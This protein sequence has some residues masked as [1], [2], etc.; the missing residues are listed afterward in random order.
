[1]SRTVTSYPTRWTIPSGIKP[2]GSVSMLN[3]TFTLNA[4]PYILSSPQNVRNLHYAVGCVLRTPVKNITIQNISYVNGGYKRGL[5]SN[6][7]I[8]H[9]DTQNCQPLVLSTGR[10]L[11]TTTESVVDITILYPS[12]DVQAMDLSSLIGVLKTSNQLQVYSAPSVSNQNTQELSVGRIVGVVFAVIAMTIIVTSMVMYSVSK[13]MNRKPVLTA[14][15]N[16]SYGRK[17]AFVPIRV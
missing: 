9:N 1:M 13:V 10:L 3:L 15:L 16:P 14:V 12:S 2:I 11:Q 5:L 7:S 4:N 8:I 6:P 17:N